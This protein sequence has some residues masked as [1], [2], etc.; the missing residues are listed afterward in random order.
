MK[1][2]LRIYYVTHDNGWLTGVL[3]RTWGCWFDAPPPSAYG[4]DEDDI[5][6]Q[7]EAQLQELEV[8]GEGT[9]PIGTCGMRTSACGV[10]RWTSILRRSS[11][12]GR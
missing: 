11:R 3:M 7:L 2:S 9:T 12:S 1:K 5:E 4:A 6:L 10:W 8:K